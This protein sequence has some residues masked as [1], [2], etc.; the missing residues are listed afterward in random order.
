[1]HG[2]AT[3]SVARVSLFPGLEAMEAHKVGLW[4]DE[5]VRVDFIS[6]FS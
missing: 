5:K 4:N 1:M 6:H 2:Y 3:A